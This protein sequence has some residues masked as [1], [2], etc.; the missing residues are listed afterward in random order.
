MNYHSSYDAICALRRCAFFCFV[1]AP[2]L[3]MFVLLAGLSFNNSIA[4]MYVDNARQLVANAPADKVWD[5]T[6]VRSPNSS[7]VKNAV[8][9]AVPD[10]LE[11]ECHPRLRNVVDWQ[12]DIDV[13]IRQLY[14]LTALLGL[15]VWLVAEGFPR[16]SLSW[17]KKRVKP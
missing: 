9:V 5:T 7:E 2:S 12:K 4:G 15:V 13:S 11:P 16:I 3:M 1:T 6:C 8:P 17:L 14:L 10:Y